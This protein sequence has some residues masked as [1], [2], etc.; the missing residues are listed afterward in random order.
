M[1]AVNSWLRLAI[2]KD[3]G[4]SLVAAQD[5]AMAVGARKAFEEHPNREKWLSL[6]YLGCDGMPN[7][8]QAWVRRGLLAATVVI[9]PNAG[10]A[11]EMAARAIE[12][13]AQPLERSFTTPTS[14]PP[15]G[16]LL[17]KR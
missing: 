13:K 3:L 17:P 8:G 12:T 2:A 14:Y 11:I 5:D 1:Q 7:T 9:P 6:P 4:I 15:I 16:A 10:Q